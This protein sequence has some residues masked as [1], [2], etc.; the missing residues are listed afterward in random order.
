MI[1][2]QELEAILTVLEKFNVLEFASKDFTISLKA[3]PKV[4][5]TK[6]LAQTNK[7]KE[8]EEEEL[9]FYSAAR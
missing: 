1:S 8:Q 7:T 6:D 5:T 2:P 4:E 9:L 3:K